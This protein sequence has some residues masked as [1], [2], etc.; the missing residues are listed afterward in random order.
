MG[1]IQGLAESG[2]LTGNTLIKTGK[3]YVFSVTFAWKGGVAGERCILRDGVDESGKAEVV[4]TTILAQGTRQLHW[5]QGKEFDTGI[6]FDREE[7]T[8]TIEV[9]LTYK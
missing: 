9:E 8:G 6:Y 7:V 3:G 2:V 5:P 1:R 4:F